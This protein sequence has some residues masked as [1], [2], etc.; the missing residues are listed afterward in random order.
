[1]ICFEKLKS[2]S[3]ASKD[4]YCPCGLTESKSSSAPGIQ[5]EGGGWLVLVL[6][7]NKGGPAKGCDVLL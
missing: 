3:H 4:G 7:L 1:M 6:L 2:F 5:A